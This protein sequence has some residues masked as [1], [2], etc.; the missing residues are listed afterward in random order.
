MFKKQLLKSSPFGLQTRSGELKDKNKWKKNTH[1]Q[2]QTYFIKLFSSYLAICDQRKKIVCFG[3]QY[4]CASCKGTAEMQ[5]NKSSTC[6]PVTVRQANDD[7][8]GKAFETQIKCKA[9]SY[10]NNSLS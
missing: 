5:K 6:F 1:T 9:N 7:K 4:P 8:A 10:F 2:R 3:D